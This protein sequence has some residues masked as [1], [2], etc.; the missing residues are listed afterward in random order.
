MY[1]DVVRNQRVYMENVISYRNKVTREEMKEIMQVIDLIILRNHAKRM[2][3][4]ITVTHSVELD[5]KRIVVDWEIKIAIDKEVPLPKDFEF[6]PVFE[7]EKVMRV[8]V[9]A[10]HKSVNAAMPKVMEIVDYYKN[11]PMTPFY[12]ETFDNGIE[13]YAEI[14]VGL[15]RDC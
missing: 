11:A 4:P 13:R 1:E 6:L 2:S 12:V 3:N 15:Y 7:V 8:R 10:D 9:P 14:F 5:R